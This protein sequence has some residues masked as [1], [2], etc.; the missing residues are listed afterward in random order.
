MTF[1]VEFWCYIG[2]DPSV[3]DAS[4]L[5]PSWPTTLGPNAVARG[6]RPLTPWGT[7]SVEFRCYIGQDPSVVDAS[8]L[9]P[10]W[11]T[12][13]GP[14]AVTRGARPLT[15]WGTALCPSVNKIRGVQRMV[16]KTEENAL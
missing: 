2:Q 11:P 1:S 5:L 4:R 3:V 8:R 10:S 12:A 14:N 15:P 7:F 16:K 6:A 13:L 9:L